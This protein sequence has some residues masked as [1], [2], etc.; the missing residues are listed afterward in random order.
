MED[1]LSLSAWRSYL[2]PRSAI[3][4]ITVALTAL[5]VWSG[6]RNLFWGHASAGAAVL[7]ALQCFVALTGVMLVFA[8]VH[9]WLDNAPGD[10]TA[11]PTARMVMRWQAYAA[12]LGSSLTAFYLGWWLGE[13]DAAWQWS[14]VPT[15][16]MV[17]FAIC[18]G[19]YANKTT[20]DPHRG[21]P[22][23]GR[24]ALVFQGMISALTFA[25]IGAF[26]GGNTGYMLWLLGSLLSLCGFAFT[27]CIYQNRVVPEID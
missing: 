4:L 27:M 20:S 25:L 5:A 12:C 24:R 19:F 26:K 15:A 1:D 21:Y 7:N 3:R 2:T 22:G 10:R 16:C 8:F 18:Y 11:L 6:A 23:Q 14:F 17:L 13:A 9:A